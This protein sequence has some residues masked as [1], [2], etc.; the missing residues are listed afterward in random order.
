MDQFIMKIRDGSGGCWPGSEALSS[1]YCTCLRTSF[2]VQCNPV[3]EFNHQ[4]IIWFF[5][6]I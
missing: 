2:L 6:G 1:G 3:G 5:I 4:R